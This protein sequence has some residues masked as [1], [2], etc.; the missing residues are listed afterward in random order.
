M[1]F[2]T[3]ATYFAGRVSEKLGNRNDRKEQVKKMKY[4]KLF[5][6]FG[7]MA[8]VTALRSGELHTYTHAASAAGVSEQESRFYGKVI[9]IEGQEI[10]LQTGTV[11]FAENEF[12][13]DGQ[14]R[15]VTVTDATVF[16][17]AQQTEGET[18]S[19]AS[20]QPKDVAAVILEEGTDAAAAVTRMTSIL[21][22]SEKEE[23]TESLEPSETEDTSKTSGKEPETA[24][25]SE[26]PE[27]SAEMIGGAPGN[28][29]EPPQKPEGEAGGA[30][31]PGG[32]P[33]NAPGGMPGGAPGNTGVDSYDAVQEYSGSTD[34]SGKE[35]TSTGTDENAVLVDGEDASV[36]IADCDV[37][38]TSEDSSGG[39]NASFYGVGAAMLVT[40]GELT[41]ENSRITTDADG[42]AGVFAYG[43]GTALV[44]DTTIKT[45]RNT[46][47]GIHA[48]GGGTL[49]AWDLDVVTDGGSAAAIRSDRGGGTMVVD[50]GTYTSN[51]S[52]SPAIYCTADIS[53][54]DA[55]LNATGSEAV[56]I[57]GLNTLRLF[58]C[59][60]TGDMP[61]QEQN[62]NT[63]N[64]IVYQSMSGD[65]VEGNGTFEMSGGTLTAKN[66]GMFYTTN[67]ES[68]ITLKDV[69]ITNAENAPF[70]LQV[71]GNSNARGWGEAGNNGADCLFTAISQE[72]EGD[73]IW[74]SISRL[75][76]Y[77]TDHSLLT[78]AFVQDETWAGEGGSGYCSVVIDADSEWVVTGDSKVTTLCCAGTIEDEQGQS[79]TIQG[80]DGTVYE[81][82]DSPY[83]I[84]TDHY[85]KSADTSEAG[86]ISVWEDYQKE[87]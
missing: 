65:S 54:H 24:Q 6:I 46:S 59:D 70:F 33:G 57:E 42:A 78:G 31:A 77:L 38:R 32:M 19:F 16:K 40:D 35:I 61:D 9:R 62:D 76:F 27:D 18:A 22:V 21:Q 5:V 85:E 68:T 2:F 69:D 14:E 51:G 48:A 63:W 8:A 25:K 15:T 41:V 30:G 44:K 71:T 23:E 29:Q 39:D 53:V 73:V 60:L 28:G 81:E 58:D 1:I 13:P 36:Q 75:D 87:I 7:I 20:L 4:K 3:E 82:G 47:G 74:D 43:S 84:T 11:D 66:G 12:T 83:T 80:T 50:G 86:A 45:S 10:T 52:G 72:M 79:V 64:V 26:D 34:L 17:D 37:T 67:T 49:Y 55:E 56:C